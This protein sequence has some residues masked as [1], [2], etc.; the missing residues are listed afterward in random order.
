M[1]VSDFVIEIYLLLGFDFSDFS[2]LLSHGKVF[3]NRFRVLIVVFLIVTDTKN[4]RTSRTLMDI[5][6]GTPCLSVVIV[7]SDKSYCSYLELF[8]R[9]FGLKPATSAVVEHSGGFSTKI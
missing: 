7:S 1:N 2:F 8:A 5:V 3:E 4:W 6:C 9:L